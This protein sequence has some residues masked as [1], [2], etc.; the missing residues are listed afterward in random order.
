[1]DAFVRKS[2]GLNGLFDASSGRLIMASLGLMRALNVPED[3]EQQQVIHR[4]PAVSGCLQR[5][6][7]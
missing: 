1:M 7:L 3:V 4:R 2:W 5:L 6:K